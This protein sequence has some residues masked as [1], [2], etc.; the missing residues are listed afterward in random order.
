M[1]DVT[2]EDPATLRRTAYAGG[3]GIAVGLLLIAFNA[4]GPLATGSDYGGSNVL[5]AALGSF[6]L[7]MF[8][9]PTY[10]ALDRLGWT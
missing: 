2:D 3:L 10:D 5:F 8:A 6:L 4:L 7:V 1:F 9:K